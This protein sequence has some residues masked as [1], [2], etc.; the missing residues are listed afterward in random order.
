M[1]KTIPQLSRDHTATQPLAGSISTVTMPQFSREQAASQP[2]HL[3]AVQPWLTVELRSKGVLQYVLNLSGSSL[4]LVV[5][6]VIHTD[7]TSCASRRG[8]ASEVIQQRQLQ[9]LKT[10]NLKDSGDVDH[11]T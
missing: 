5:Q 4:Q 7:S 1:N 6:D 11:E 8:L 3:T 10:L 2:W 9:E